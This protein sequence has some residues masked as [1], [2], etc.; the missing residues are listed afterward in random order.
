MATRVWFSALLLAFL[1]AASPF[2]QVAR[3]QS[4]EDAATAEVVEGADLGIVGDDTQVSSDEPL[5]PAPGVETVCVFPKNAGKIVL[6]GE[7]TELLVGLQNEGE[8][9]LNVVAVHSTLHLPFD[10]RMYGQNLTVQN[11]FNA[12]V[13]V[14]VQATFPYTFAV[15]KFLQNVFYNGTI[16]VVEAGGF[17]SVESVFLITLGIALLTLFGLW[18]YGQVQQLSKKTKKVPKVELGTGTTDSSID[19]W[20][21]GTSFVQGSKSKKK[22]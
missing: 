13:P 5:S 15:S 11:F 17:L 22:K 4:E 7:E 3:A 12:S 16:E 18:A 19:E 1:L 20:L 14:S 21:E 6:A 8:S 9:T 2:I 10:H